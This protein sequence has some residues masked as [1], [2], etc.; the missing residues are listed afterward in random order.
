MSY[1]LKPLDAPGGAFDRASEANK[2]SIEIAIDTRVN[3]R[4][5]RSPPGTWISM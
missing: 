4:A 3:H 2:A 5:A 1:L